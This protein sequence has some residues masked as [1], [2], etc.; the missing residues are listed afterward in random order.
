MFYEYF[1]MLQG[2]VWMLYLNCLCGTSRKIV[3]SSRRI[4]SV[5]VGSADFLQSLWKLIELS[6]NYL[7]MLRV[8]FELFM[9]ELP[10]SV[11]VIFYRYVTRSRIFSNVIMYCRKVYWNILY[12]RGSGR[13][14]KVL[15]IFW[16]FL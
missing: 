6:G 5:A 9:R 11:Y 14:C 4:C 13:L 10:E 1:L 16:Y 7:I 2:N 12:I 15:R 3:D 8:A